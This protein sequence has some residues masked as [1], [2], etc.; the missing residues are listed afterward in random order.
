MSDFLSTKDLSKR[1]GVTSERVQQWAAEGYLPSKRLGERAYI[2]DPI[3]VDRFALERQE[4]RER[5]NRY[6]VGTHTTITGLESQGISEAE[7]KRRFEAADPYKGV[8]GSCYF[9]SLDEPAKA[10]KEEPV[11]GS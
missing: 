9:F 4:R 3:D 6:A 11:S 5:K 8:T 10:V 1:F 2:F 7:A